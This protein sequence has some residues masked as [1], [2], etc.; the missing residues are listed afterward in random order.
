M[1]GRRSSPET[2]SNLAF[3]RVAWGDGQTLQSDLSGFRDSKKHKGPSDPKT[4][5][6]AVQKKKARISGLDEM[7]RKDIEEKE[8][9]LA[10]K[11][12][13]QGEKVH[14]DPDR[15]KKT[16]KRKEKAKAKSKQEWK[17]R[18]AGIEKGKEM[19][20]K[21]R[22]MNLKRRKEDSKRGVKGSKVK[23]PSKKKPKRPGFE[24]TMKGR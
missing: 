11:K 7:K 6:E 19:K 15:L 8:L 21:K 22:E 12:K 16:L 5:L 23:K 20:Q 18:I 14:D 9:W 24:G 10:A 17:E 1:L 3:G 2:E 4:A 13:A